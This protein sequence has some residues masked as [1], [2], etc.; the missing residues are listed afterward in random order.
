M[1][2]RGELRD[3]KLINFSVKLEEILPL[4]PKSFRVLQEN[5]RAIISMVDVKLKNMY[6]SIF[7]FFKFGYRYVAFRLL[8]D[9]TE[10]SGINKPKGV[11]FLK[12]FCNGFILI[13][14]GGCSL[15]VYISK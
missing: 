4:V 14:N 15:T 8:L 9:D 13:F 3:I 5:G 12:N 7:P 1:K 2:F 6:P 11:Y 10:I